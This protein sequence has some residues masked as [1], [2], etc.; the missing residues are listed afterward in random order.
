LK[1]QLENVAEQ[2]ESLDQ[3]RDFVNQQL[4]DQ[5]D[6]ERDAFPFSERTL[7][8]GGKPCGKLFCLHGP[9][10]VQLNAV[11][12]TASNTVIFYGSNGEKISKLALQTSFELTAD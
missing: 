7:F 6:F 12:E 5:N 8:Q 4:C 10:S 9:R 1:T 3:M 11:W 2:I